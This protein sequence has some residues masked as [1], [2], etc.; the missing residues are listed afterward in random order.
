MKFVAVI[1]LALVSWT[2]S[3]QSPCP[4]PLSASQLQQLR[5]DDS[6][7]LRTYALTRWFKCGWPA[8][9]PAMK[10]WRTAA[11]EAAREDAAEY[12]DALPTS[13]E[14]VEDLRMMVWMSPEAFDMHLSEEFT[15]EPNEDDPAQLAALMRLR[16]DPAQMLRHIEQGRTAV[17]A[18]LRE[19][20]ALPAA[21][22][23]VLELSVVAQLIRAGKIDEARAYFDRIERQSTARDVQLADVA[24]ATRDSDAEAVERL[25]SMR[26]V[27]GPVGP[28]SG[29]TTATR[30]I[31][32]RSQAARRN[33][34]GT[35]AMMERLFDT[36]YL[37]D[38]VLRAADAD[39]AIA[40]ALTVDWRAQVNGAGARSGLLLDLLRKRYGKAGLEQ[41]WA[42]A[43]AGLR[44]DG[45]SIGVVLFGHYLAMPDAV[46]ESDASSP[47][48]THERPLRLDELIN[49]VKATALYRA[50]HA[51]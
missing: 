50:S 3:A 25:D 38:I 21:T 39:A 35:G 2:A 47:G 14:F 23:L 27:L 41:G 32:Y 24:D 7:T 11:E 16:V 9:L 34:C 48:A 43:L 13:T 26:A 31:I 42:D 15:E 22:D 1:A 28:V 30:W 20:L 8:A 49:L 18:L 36:T 6:Y 29:A 51:D 40:E 12:K 10:V 19:D 5:D 33:F 45:A 17:I 44:T 4:D 46:V 37:R